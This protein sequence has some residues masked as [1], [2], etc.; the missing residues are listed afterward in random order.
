MKYDDDITDVVVCFIRT[1]VSIVIY[2]GCVVCQHVVAVV[3][4]GCSYTS[5]IASN[6]VVIVVPCCFCYC[7]FVTF[8][9][10]YHCLVCLTL[11]LQLLCALLLAILTVMLCAVLLFCVT[12]LILIL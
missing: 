1:V 6:C 12:L 3:D 9:C 7:C 4:V 5:R 2:I 11:L 10:H 8:C